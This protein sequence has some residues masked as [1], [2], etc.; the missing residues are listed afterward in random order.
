[1]QTFSDFGIYVPASADGQYYTQCPK[2]S[3]GRRKHKKKCLSVQINEGKWN[4]HHC[5]FRGRLKPKNYQAKTERVAPVDYSKKQLTPRLTEYFKERGI[6][7]N[8]L[9]SHDVGYQDGWI[10]FPYKRNDDIAN[11]K[12]RKTDSREFRQVKGARKTVYGYN[13]IQGHETIIITEGEIDKLSFD[14]AEISACCSVPDGAPPSDA[15]DFTTK[16]DY[17]EDIEDAIAKADKI[18]LAT[19]NDKPGYRL[20][21]ELA[22]RIGVEKC[23]IMDYPEDCK[24]ANDVLVKYG[25]AKLKEC[26][27]NVRQFPVEGIFKPEDFFDRLDRLYEDG[28]EKAFSTGWP[29]LDDYFKIRLGELTIITGIPS[30]GK[31]A[32]LDDLLV[33]IAGS[34]S[35]QIAVFSPEYLPLQRHAAS[36]IEKYIGRCFDK[37]YSNHMSEE[38]F[39]QG[40]EWLNQ[41]FEFILPEEEATLDTI[42]EK[43]RVSI[44]RSGTQILVIDP[45]NELDDMIPQGLNETRYISMQLKKIRRFARKYKVHV[46]VVAHPTKMRKA[47]PDEPEPVPTLYDVNGSANF[48]NRTDNGLCIWRDLRDDSSEVKVYVQKVKFREVGRIGNVSLYFDTRNGKY[49]EQPVRYNEEPLN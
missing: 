33:R 3:A 34:Y 27:V 26:L 43:A 19:D 8:I 31:T 5:G 4:C 21:E 15:K 6:P 7:E 49:N 11:V 29:T 45:W 17:L 9:E 47:K 44:F 28:P 38:Q 42:L 14:T 36:L 23:W 13:D 18:I 41:Y 35:W 37:G 1:M 32:W 22:R 12:Y 24:D 46:F 10:E 30:H 40:K 48:R 20:R 16:F 25:P 39:N 2:C